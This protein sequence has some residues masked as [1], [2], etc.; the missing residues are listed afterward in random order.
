MVCSKS[1][2]EKAQA[3]FGGVYRAAKDGQMIVEKV[4][5]GTAALTVAKDA[6]VTAAT[7][8]GSQPFAIPAPVIMPR[9]VLE[10]FMQRYDMYSPIQN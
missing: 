5:A 1:K 9:A 8:L 3:Q 7:A 4:V 2:S 10:E 6:V